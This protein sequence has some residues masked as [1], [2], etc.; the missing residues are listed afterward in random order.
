MADPD[1]GSLQ[2]LVK[3]A[4]LREKKNK[5]GGD[6]RIEP[7]YEYRDT[8]YSP[9]PL[10]VYLASQDLTIIDRRTRNSH[11]RG[12]RKGKGGGGRS[13]L[14]CAQHLIPF[15]LLNGR[16]RGAQNLRQA[17]P[18]VMS[19]LYDPE[20]GKKGKEGEESC[21]ASSNFATLRRRTLGNVDDLGS[22]GPLMKLGSL[23]AIWGRRGGG[24]R[25]EKGKIGLLRGCLP[26]GDRGAIFT[27]NARF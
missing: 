17:G 8:F 2:P 9:S 10:R 15:G 26:S 20:H 19:P 1:L 4:S 25:A 6:E 18:G 3:T 11:L 12:K 21:R 13:K 5:K 24:R 14:E 23:P 7:R 16:E 22:S 27:G